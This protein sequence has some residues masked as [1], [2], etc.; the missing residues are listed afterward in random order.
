[1][2]SSVG[3]VLSASDPCSLPRNEQQVADVKRRLKR[4]NSGGSDE[5]AVVMQKA[6]LE[7]GGNQF[8]RE[9]KILRE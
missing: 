7:D 5:L 1:M 8:I 4:S 3:G 9:M 6:Y 2:S